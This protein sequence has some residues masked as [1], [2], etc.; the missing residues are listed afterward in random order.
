MYI[1][2]HKIYIYDYIYNMAIYIMTIYIY[3][4]YIIQTYKNNIYVYMID[5]ITKYIYNNIYIY[6]C[7]HE[8]YILVT[9]MS[10]F[11][12]VTDIHHLNFISK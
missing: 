11:S 2:N 9:I 3:I 1:C 4:I 10:V 7:N 12:Y 6:I 8:T 5:I